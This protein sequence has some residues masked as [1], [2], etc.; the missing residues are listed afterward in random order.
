ELFR[1]RQQEELQADI[2]ALLDQFTSSLSE[3]LDYGAGLDIFCAG[4]NRLFGAD[5]TSVWIHDRR[6]RQLVLRASSAPEQS[7]ESLTV[8]VDD[9][10][11]IAAVAMRHARAEMAAGGPDRHTATVT[12]PLRGTRRALGTIVLEGVRLDAGAELDTLDRADALGR[13]LAVAIENTQL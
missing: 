4:A 3:N 1:H 6:A 7:A 8:A 2:R 10:T 12:I 13:Q 9:P 11:A 5:R